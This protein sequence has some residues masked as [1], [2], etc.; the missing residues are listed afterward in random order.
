[1]IHVQVLLVG[2]VCSVCEMHTGLGR[3]ANTLTVWVANASTH[4]T[5]DINCTGS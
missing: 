4:A 3:A 5:M 2:S 1:M